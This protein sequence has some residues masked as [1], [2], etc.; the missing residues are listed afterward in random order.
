MKSQD[1]RLSSLMLW[2]GAE[3][4]LSATAVLFEKH[5]KKPACLQFVGNP[6][7]F[8]VC[9]TIELALKAY[10]RG[11]G[12]DERF[13][14][15]E[16]GHDL[17]VAWNAAESVGLK[18]LVELTPEDT[19]ILDFAN[20]LYSSKALQFSITGFYQYPPFE[21]L[22]RLAEKLVVGIEAFCVK[23]VDFH[24]GK[25]TAVHALRVSKKQKRQ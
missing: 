21:P 7:Y 10:L 15:N 25:P 22:L 9:Q 11:C 5:K 14:A 6:A 23:N 13:L 20:Q 1:D 8:L 12:K 18:S 4:Y 17:F 16:C 2:N 19:L 24:C 3:E